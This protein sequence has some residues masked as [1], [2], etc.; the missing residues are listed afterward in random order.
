VA[1]AE[2][3]NVTCEDHGKPM[4]YQPVSERWECPEPGCTAF[5]DL[6]R[7]QLMPPGD[8]AVKAE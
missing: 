8:V 2:G 4:P 1:P 6:W 5:L 3:R 7:E